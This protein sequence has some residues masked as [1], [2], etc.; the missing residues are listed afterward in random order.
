MEKNIEMNKIQEES[1]E[2]DRLA[3]H[4]SVKSRQSKALNSHRSIR[5]KSAASQNNNFKRQGSRRI[6]DTE[7]DPS[8]LISN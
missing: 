8:K 5:S 2:Y 1:V 6:P 4:R 7:N 3:S